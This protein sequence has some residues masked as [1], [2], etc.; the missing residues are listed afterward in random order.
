VLETLHQHNVS[1]VAV[2]WL[3]VMIIDSA[4]LSAS[5]ITGKYPE[6][7]QWHRNSFLNRST[8]TITWLGY[9]L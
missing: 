9:K 6:W 8:S 3:N 5:Y 1:S 4:H 2:C 7:L